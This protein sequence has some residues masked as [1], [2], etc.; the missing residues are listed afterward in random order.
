MGK[1]EN[2]IQRLVIIDFEPMKASAVQINALR[3]TAIDKAIIPEVR[4]Y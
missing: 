2:N 1:V 3:A 4:I